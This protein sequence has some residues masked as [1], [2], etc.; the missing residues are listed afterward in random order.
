MGIS[1]I[2]VLVAALVGP[3]FVDWT[4]YRSTFETYAE[5]ALGHKVTVLGEADLRL[6]P[7]PFVRF[8]DVRVGPAED[9]LLVVSQFDMRI[10]LPP[11]LKGE[12]RVMDMQLERPHLSLSLDEEGRLDW[13][14]AMSTDGALAKLAPED[15]AFDQVSI[16]D[17]A[18]TIVDAR[19]EETH[20]IDNANLSVSARTLE[21]PFRATGSLTVEG[22]PYSISLATGRAQA[23]SDLRVKGEVTPTQWPVNFTFDGLLGQAD[24]APEFAGSFGLNSIALDENDPGRWTAEGEFLA[25]ISEVAIPAF[26]FR[27][28]P[29]DKR[30]SLTGNADLVYAGNKRFEVRANSNQVDLDRL[31]GGGPS[32]PINVA[33][34]GDQLVQALQSVPL[35]PIDGVISFDV[36]AVVAGG[37]IVQNV[38]LDLETM[39]GGWRVARLAGRLPGRTVVATQGDFGLEPDLTY[40]GAFSIKSEQPGSFISWVRQSGTGS[41]VLKPVALEG[42]LNLAADGAAVDNL[43]V[44]LAGAEARGGLAYRRPRTGNDVFSLSLDADRLNLDEIEKLAGLVQPEKGADDE[45]DQPSELDVSLRL[46]AREVSARGVD[47]KGLTLEAE[48]TDGGVRIDRLFAEDLAGARFDVSG[49]IRNLLSTPEGAISGTLDARDLSGLVAL[50]GG[51]FPGSTLAARLEQSAANLV[52]ARFEANLQASAL[53]DETDLQLDLTGSAG[54]T[55]TSLSFGLNGRVDEWQEADL[56]LALAMAGPDGSRVLQ[57]LGLDVIPVDT[58]GAGDLSAA[59]TGTPAKGLAVDLATQ[60][61]GA[62]LEAQGTAKLAPGED[63]EVRLAVKSSAEDLVPVALMSG[64]VLP[65]LGGQLSASLSFDLESIGDAVEINSISGQI[66][67]TSFTGDLAGNLDLVPGEQNRRVT[68][69]LAINQ[70]DLRTLSELVLGPD[71]WASLGDGTS[72]WPTAPF[73]AP[74]LDGW[75]LT[76]GL[77][78]DTLLADDDTA[79]QN[80]KAEFRLTPTMMRL[81]GLAGAYAGGALQGALSIRRTEAEAAVSGRVKLDN[82]DIRQLSWRRAGRSVA[83]GSLDVFLEFE[84]VGRSISA[85][86]SSLNGGGTFSMSEGDIRGLNPQAFPLVIRAVDAGLDLRDEKIEEVFVS[87]MAAG[88]LPFKAIDGTLTLVGGRLS[89]R[90]VVVDAERAEVF[91]SAEIDFSDHELDADFALKVDPGE[92]AV[93]GAEPQV[94][95]VFQGPLDAPIRQ[96]DITPFTAYLTLRA[97]EQEVE[98]V[99]R[100]QAEILER[101]RLLRELNR[102]QEARA[103]QARLAAEAEA[104]E[105]R[106]LEELENAPDTSGQEQENSARPQET[107]PQQAASPAED[108]ASLTERIRAVLNSQ[109]EAP[110]TASVGTPETKPETGLPPLEPPVSIDD[111]ISR[112]IGVPANG[113][114]RGDGPFVLPGVSQ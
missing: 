60:I 61:G 44:T 79:L 89:A 2:L 70:A 113:V 33:A 13:L 69:S 32:E 17:G 29:D 100:L 93:T 73:G 45:A 43:R 39:L 59:L 106:R 24:A 36:P 18:L 9:P 108:Q 74:L 41:V 57:Q 6:L 98:R 1:V 49:Q 71:Q 67:Q 21:G 83:S 81:D 42:R 72:S 46:R 53:G 27:Y 52:P 34:A 75:D 16:R 94:G 68:G 4:V 109:E 77:T 50:V 58:I 102:Q 10:E 51:A 3:F 111:L 103:R 25:S 86:V 54:G 107:Q 92:N 112:E 80:A 26:E 76:I 84:G 48:Y 82:A 88:T 31:L 5:R 37:G 35:P 95:L 15:L 28:G 56:D 90:N 47:G 55:Q 30:L 96:V 110:V 62:R 101:D 97:F 40:R 22:A 99:E 8:S 85:M 63:P 11:L 38:L 20:Q 87:H 7:A 19:S 78:A 12:I 64:R 104:E 23:G 66:A 105:Q 91:G 14:T 114:G 65:I